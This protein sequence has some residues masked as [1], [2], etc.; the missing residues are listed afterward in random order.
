[1]DSGVR[2]SNNRWV[3]LVALVL[4][5]VL[6]GWISGGRLS[7]LDLADLRLWW[8]APLGLVIQVIPVRDPWAFPALMAS[9]AALVAFAV[10]NIRKPGIPLVLVGLAMNWL[11]IG[12]NDGMPVDATALRD[13]EAVMRLQQ[14]GGAKHHLMTGADTLADLGDRIWVP[15]LREI[16]S[17]GDLAL[18]VGVAWFIA[19]GMRRR[20]PYRGRH[21]PGADWGAET[22]QPE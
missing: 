6:I 2:A 20:P 18:Y 4:A 1:M 16:Y 17:P 15:G 13:D 8:L 12:L 5:A 10:A 19:A 14:E 7:N 3:L 21:A 22:D 11:V 9:Y